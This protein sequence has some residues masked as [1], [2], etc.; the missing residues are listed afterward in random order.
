[1]YLSHPSL[2]EMDYDPEGFQW[3]NCSYDQESLAIFIRRSK[4]PEET[5]LFVCNFDNMPHEKFRLGVPFAGKY[6]EILNSDA[7]EFGG[8]GMT[9]PRAKTSKA[10]EWDEQE[11]SIEI[12]VAPMSCCVFSCVPAPEEKAVKGKKGAKAA[13]GTKTGA[14]EPVHSATETSKSEAAEPEKAGQKGSR[15]DTVKKTARKLAAKKDELGR[16]AAS[17]VEDVQKAAAEKVETV[18]KAAA[19]K[20]ETVQK[21]AAGRV[22]K[23]TTRKTEPH[24]LATKKEEPHMLAT[25]KEEPHKLET[26][27]EEPHKLETKKGETHKIETKKEEP[28]KIATAKTEPKKIAEKKE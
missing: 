8:T 23:L 21:A 13:S 27:K 2:Y 18:Q 1:M 15:L 4:K 14:K 11:N 24:K 28:R 10:I 26:K 7:E 9:N 5:L 19:E 6:K 17:K 12:R 3:I 16:R 20:V 25:K 22:E